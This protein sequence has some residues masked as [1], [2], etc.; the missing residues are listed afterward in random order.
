MLALMIV[1]AMLGVG[2]C[3]ITYSPAALQDE[4]DYSVLPGAEDIVSDLNFKSFS[5]YLDVDGE[6]S[7]SKRLHYWL[8]ESQS[9]P[10][11][12]PIA[13]WTNGGPGCSGMLAMMT[14]HGPLKLTEEG[15]LVIN[16]Y[17]H[18]LVSSLFFVEQPI[19][20]GLSYSA[21]P[22][23][24]N[25]SDASAAQDNYN[26][27][28]A[29]LV[30]FPHFASSDLYITSESYGGHYMPTLAR[31]ILQQNDAAVHPA[32]NFKGLW[33]GNPYVDYYSGVGSMFDT[34]WARSL[35]AKPVWD[36]YNEH[37][38]K[39]WFYFPLNYDDDDISEEAE[40]ACEGP[41]NT[42][43]LNG[44]FKTNVYA[45]DWP[46]CPDGSPINADDDDFI[47]EGNRRALLTQSSALSALGRTRQG[48]RLVDTLIASYRGLKRGF[49]G[50]VSAV[51]VEEVEVEVASSGDE[52]ERRQRRLYNAMEEDGV[53]YNPCED[54]WISSWFNKPLVKQALHV[55]EDIQW[56]ECAHAPFYFNE[57]DPLVS[58]VP[59]YKEILTHPLA[60][61]LKVLVFSGT[62]D[63]VCATSGTQRWIWDLGYAV[64][65]EMDWVPYSV[66]QQE[67][68]FVTG[69]KDSPLV[70]ATVLNAGHEV[71]TYRPRESLA[72]WKTFL[73]GTW[74]M[75]VSS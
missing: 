30:R 62:D 41:L 21:F 43:Y 1:V 29:M 75:L 14:E 35:V 12:D 48:A 33:V 7:S 34:F 68:G 46:V 57:T 3:A 24:Y 71:P 58:M 5:G 44:E 4:V 65:P 67:A 72:L 64:D 50:K 52:D 27:I 70:F 9:A 11:T 51:Q 39:E 74:H 8:V 22:L 10:E 32:I 59:V 19:G 38:P 20:V 31:E 13:F 60:Q 15:N 23:D 2:E 45:I 37:C 49:K 55:K 73:A 28:Q 25:S 17:A 53:D 61:T 42:L 54:W 40:A 63:S 26:V 6:E 56:R 69:F 47:G 18:N 16:P 36:A 66:D